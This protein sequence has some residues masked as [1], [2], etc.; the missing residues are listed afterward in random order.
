MMMSVRWG[1]RVRMEGPRR[2][3]RW[4]ASRCLHQSGLHQEP[5]P[6]PPFPTA[7]SVGG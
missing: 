6:L 7:G 1:D 5:G 2:S 4:A 3:A